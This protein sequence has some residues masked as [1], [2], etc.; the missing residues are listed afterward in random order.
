MPVSAITASPS[1]AAQ[2][3][4][5]TSAA[6]AT[7]QVASITI[8]VEIQLVPTD[9]VG[10]AGRPSQGASLM[11][12]LRQL[13]EQDP[14]RFKKV[15]K[16]VAGDL[17]AEA[18]KLGGEKAEFLG[19]L[20]SRFEKAAE[21]GNLEALL[22]RG[23]HHHH[24]HE[25]RRHHGAR[26]YEGAQEHADV[27]SAHHRRL[28]LASFVRR[29]LEAVPAS[30]PAGASPGGPLASGDTTTTATA[31]AAQAAPA[32]ADPAAAPVSVAA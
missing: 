30:A 11:G 1:A 4:G 9:K 12:Q 14:E 6:A 29:A 22:A 19:Q 25:H 18:E 27:A 16:Q 31:P 5:G 20:A 8:R 13:Q 32:A 24:H 21:T 17:R 2:V 10:E 15:M 28:D 7:F 3:A 23:H 26:R